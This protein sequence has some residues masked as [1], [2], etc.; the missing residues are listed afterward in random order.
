VLFFD[1][2][3]IPPDDYLAKVVR[4]LHADY[5]GVGGPVRDMGDGPRTCAR[6]SSLGDVTRGD[7]RGE[8]SRLL[9]GNM[10]IRKS[11]FEEVGLFDER[12]S[13]RGDETEW[14]SRS[15]HLRFFYDPDLWAWHRRDMFSL[16][17]L[18]RHAFRQGKATP[19]F[20]SI[21]GVGPSGRVQRAARYGA[22]ALLHR[23]SHGLEL[24]FRELGALAGAWQ[25][26]VQ[27]DSGP[28]E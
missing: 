5:D 12:L 9:G 24:S 14:F 10:A 22:H 11:A 7:E 16:P 18:C 4:S 28:R 19:V 17:A 27:G 21:T 20:E 6:C 1:D 15:T 26:K 23:C 25:G 2:D 3:Q 13:G 8:N